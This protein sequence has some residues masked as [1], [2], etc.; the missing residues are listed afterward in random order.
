ML[1]FLSSKGRERGTGLFLGVSHFSPAIF[2]VLLILTALTVAAALVGLDIQ[3]TEQWQSFLLSLQV[4]IRGWAKA[5][6]KKRTG[7]RFAAAATR[8]IP[9]SIASWGKPLVLRM[10]THN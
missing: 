8:H 7:L 9:L 6:E 2:Q 10:D 5:S 1:P 4:R 3:W